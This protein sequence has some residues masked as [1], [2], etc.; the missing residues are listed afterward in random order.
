M[1]SLKLTVG[2]LD[3]L[4]VGREVRMS[5][6]NAT[7]EYVAS[8]ASDLAKIGSSITYA[9]STAST[10]TAAVEA[11]GADAVSTSISQLFGAHAA[12]YEAISSQ[13]ALFH[14]QFVQL[15]SGGATEYADTEAVNAAP[16]QAGPQAVLG[17]A[18]AA[19]HALSTQQP[20]IGS[21]AQ[22]GSLASGVP[23]AAAVQPGAAAPAA[24]AATAAAPATAP[25]TPMAATTALAAA[26]A[27]SAA[28]AAAGASTQPQTPASVPVVTPVSAPDVAGP[29]TA[30]AAPADAEAAALSSAPMLP[31]A[32]PTPQR[33]G[34]AVPQPA[35]SS[36][37]GRPPTP[38]R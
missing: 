6:V 34:P 25:V 17:G 12:A 29:L 14:Q 7:P 11:A 2:E 10:A 27:G 26:P 20:L 35:P 5:F 31:A 37:K 13:A 22:A 24:V 38:A 36:A 4:G 8:A 30:S 3:R 23:V 9:N 18:G 1:S 16:L 28:P 19:G 33:S 21:A 15:M 32:M